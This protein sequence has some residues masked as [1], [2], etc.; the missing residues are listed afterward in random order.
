MVKNRSEVIELADIRVGA[1]FQQCL[2]IKRC[3]AGQLGKLVYLQLMFGHQLLQLT[4]NFC[5]GVVRLVKRCLFFNMLQLRFC[6]KILA[7]VN[8]IRAKNLF[9]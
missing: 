7:V 1:A 5:A 3:P 4:G 9:G 8:E 2:Q 6:L